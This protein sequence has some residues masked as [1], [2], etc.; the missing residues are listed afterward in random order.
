MSA[1]P[2]KLGFLIGSGLV[3][4]PSVEAMAQTVT[5]DAVLFNPYLPVVTYGDFVTRGLQPNTK[6]GHTGR[7][8]K[9]RFDA[10]DPAAMKSGRDFGG[11]NSSA[12]VQVIV[13]GS[14]NV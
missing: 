4:L 12:P 1:T 3:S 13:S 9:W 8:G 2:K 10:D 7:D 6:F 5:N 11:G 14:I